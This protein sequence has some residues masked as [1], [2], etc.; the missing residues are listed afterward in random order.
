MITPHFPFV[1]VSDAEKRAYIWKTI[2]LLR[3]AGEP[4]GITIAGGSE[5]HDRNGNPLGIRIM[6]VIVI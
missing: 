3:K 2:V 6:K 4:L 5:F 1:K